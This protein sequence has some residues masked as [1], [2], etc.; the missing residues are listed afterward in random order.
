M[1]GGHALPRTT[2]EPPPIAGTRWVA[3]TQGLF[4]LVDEA[5]WPLVKTRTWC[6]QR[7]AHTFYAVAG[8]GKDRVYLHRFLTGLGR[9]DHV[10]NDG[11]N[12][13][14]SNLRSCSCV[15][16][17]GNMPKRRRGASRFKGVVCVRGRWLAYIDSKYL[18]SFDTEHEA[19]RTYDAA[20]EAH[21]GADFALTNFKMLVRHGLQEL[22]AAPS[23]EA[24]RAE[25]IRPA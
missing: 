18:G 12:N 13:R 9:V 2:P 20:A 10:D 8:H 7:A 5:D 1:T 4:A 22:A 6:A 3:L 24:S 25:S 14:R 21:F 11:L 19:A 23:C 15:Q 17:S 16:N